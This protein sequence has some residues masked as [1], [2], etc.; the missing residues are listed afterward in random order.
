MAVKY[1]R[2][3]VCS[4]SAI[5]GAGSWRTGLSGREEMVEETALVWRDCKVVLYESGCRVPLIRKG[6]TEGINRYWRV[7]FCLVGRRVS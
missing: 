7:C 6:S 1:E 5:G 4:S 3:I 2:G